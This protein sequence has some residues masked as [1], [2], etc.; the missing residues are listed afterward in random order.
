[1]MEQLPPYEQWLKERLTP[2]ERFAEAFSPT[3]ERL[4]YIAKAL[5]LVAQQLTTPVDGRIADAVERMEDIV[6][7][8][9]LV[10][11]QLATPVDA[12]IADAVELLSLVVTKIDTLIDSIDRL[13]PVGYPSVV[14]WGKASRGKDTTLIDETAYWQD[15]IWTG[16]E[17]AIIA[18]IGIG[19]VRKIESNDIQSL[20]VETKWTT[21]LDD[22]SVYVIRLRN[23]RDLLAPLEKANE[24]NSS[25]TADTDILVSALAPTN[26]PCLFRVNVA[27]SGAGI[28]KATIT[29][30][31]NTQTV[32]FNSGS[33]L[34]AN[35]LYMF[36]LIVH[37]GDSINFQYSA[38]ATMLVLRVQEIVGASQ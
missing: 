1:M 26:T 37:N 19:Q 30:G 14:H 13:S 8:L 21:D 32:S 31:D 10:A 18:G 12:R 6:R 4:D 5:Q 9:Q 36:D 3:D 29:K 22:T 23:L 2:W 16:Y 17:V 15:N 28:F 24:H 35:A 33:D 20:T 34:I 7:A 38:G 25:V 11:E 27:F